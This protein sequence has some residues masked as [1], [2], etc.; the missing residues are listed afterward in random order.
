[1]PRDMTANVIT[2]LT[3][4]TVRP[5][6]FLSFETSG[7][8]VYYWTGAQDVSWNGQTWLGNGYLKGFGPISQTVEVEAVGMY[9]EIAGEPAAIV[10][11]VLQSLRQFKAAEFYIG[12][13]NSSGSII[14]DPY[15]LFSGFVD[16]A[17]LV[18]SPEM[19]TARITFENKLVAM[20]KAKN[21]RYNQETQ[22]IWYSSD[23]GFEYVEQ[24]KNSFK[25][26]WGK[27]Q[28]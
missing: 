19:G 14:T 11:L 18:E 22:K 25:G 4:S 13:V 17:E 27:A 20:H 8:T 28:K 16:T 15:L 7:S 1:M 2:E 9:A 5:R 3:A 23:V 12:F 10:S 6:F 21:F 26:Y 24:L